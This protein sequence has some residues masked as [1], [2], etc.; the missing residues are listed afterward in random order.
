MSDPSLEEPDP[1][2]LAALEKRLAK[3][4]KEEVAPKP[5]VDG[6]LRM[7]DMAWR[8]VI[9]LV[10]GLGIGFGIGYGLDAL[11]GTKPWLMLIFVFFG[12]AAGVKVMLRSA[13][14]MAKAQAAAQA[15]GKEGK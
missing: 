8:M 1:E 4:R 10:A 11:L 7:A 6:N 5:A 2:R 14:D 9:E 3:L 15:A 12:L 13:N